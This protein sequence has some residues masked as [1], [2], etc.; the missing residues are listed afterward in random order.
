MLYNNIL[1][2]NKNFYTDK[3][4]IKQSFTHSRLKEDVY[5][6]LP[7]DID[8]I[9]ISNNYITYEKIIILLDHFH[10]NFGHNLWE[11][12]YS[13]FY[14][15]FYYLND[16]CNISK[17]NFQFVVIKSPN[18]IY[19]NNKHI[20][21]IE[22]ISGNKLITIE[23][24]SNVCKN[25]PMIIPNL[26]LISNV[27]IGHVHKNNMTVNMGININNLDP[28][29]IFINRI[30]NRYNISRN[31]LIDNTDKA[32]CNNIIYITNKRPYK[33]IRELFD[34]MNKK[35]CNKFN[36]KIIDYSKYNF[37]EQLKILNT[38]SI[39]IVGVGTARMASPF[40]PNGAIEI[41]TF[42]PNIYRKNFIEYFDYHAA[43][44]SKFI[45]VKNIPYYTKEEVINNKCSH[46]LEKYIKESI[47][48]IPCKIP[49]NLENN[50]PKEILDLRNH[51]NYYNLF[52]EWRN[53][54]GPNRCPSNLIEHFMD[55]LN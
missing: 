18:H 22:K 9:K 2:Y 29:E 37:E 28:V 47:N 14:S 5:K 16:K 34:K 32:K 26:L 15:L 33:G 21:M 11:H 23:Q 24:L 53:H 51:K 43:T 49:V 13:S 10:W 46:L 6:F 50:I 38:T 17:V 20:D 1:F 25:I 4:F 55:L 42:Q 35:Y 44:I 39:C 12:V 31:S 8:S 7:R 40:L 48:E 3:K 41:Q 45:T 30:Y 36:F 54:G 27:G 19:H 52:D